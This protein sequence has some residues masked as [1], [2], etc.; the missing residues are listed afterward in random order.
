MSKKFSN[1][2]L[3]QGLV[4]VRAY[5]T[6]SLGV[7]ETQVLFVLLKQGFKS[8]ESHL[9]RNSRNRNLIKFTF[10][11]ALMHELEFRNSFCTFFHPVCTS[12]VLILI[13]I[14]KCKAGILIMIGKFI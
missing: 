3:L 1:L 8:L 6:G 5:Q 7:I 11:R 9:L 14:H 10:L 13:R 12:F 2:D 4:V